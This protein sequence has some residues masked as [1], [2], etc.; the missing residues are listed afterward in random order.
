MPVTLTKTYANAPSFD[1][2]ESMTFRKEMKEVIDG[3][4]RRTVATGGV[5]CRATFKIA[6]EEHEVGATVAAA[7]LGTRS[8]SQVLSAAYNLLK[9]KLGI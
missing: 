1:D 3:N 9:T 8:L 2:W 6:D 7:D 4:T 5:I